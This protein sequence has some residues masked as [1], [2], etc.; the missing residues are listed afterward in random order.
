MSIH[1][2][3]PLPPPPKHPVYLT[4]QANENASPVISACKTGSAKRVTAVTPLF[5][6][7]RQPDLAYRKQG[8]PLSKPT[9]DSKY[10]FESVPPT[11]GHGV[12]QSDALSNDVDLSKALNKVRLSHHEQNGTTGRSHSGSLSQANSFTTHDYDVN[13]D[14]KA[15]EA[16]EAKPGYK[17]WVAQ[18]GTLIADLLTCA[19]ADQYVYHVR[20][21]AITLCRH[22]NIGPAWLHLI[23]TMLS[24]K[25][26]S[27]YPWTTYTAARC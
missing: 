19:G 3:L 13:L 16:V 22:A 8:A 9:S 2:P 10:T 27:T 1:S 5:P 6:Y 25:A 11:P 4:S 7:S 14:P 12:A 20:Q 26:S 15:V 17:R 18:A 24:T 21:L 23:C